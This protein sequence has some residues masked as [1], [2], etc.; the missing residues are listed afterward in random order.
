[1]VSTE[2]VNQFVKGVPTWT[3]VLILIV[4]MMMK[5]MMTKKVM[6]LTLL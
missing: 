6:M 5:V 1:M 3:L 2:L 4:T